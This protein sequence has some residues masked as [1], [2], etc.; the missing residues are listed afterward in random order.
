MSHDIRIKKGLNIKLK[1]KAEKTLSDLPRTK[2]YAIKPTDFHGI[3]PK[4][5]IKVGDKVKAIGSGLQFHK[6]CCQLS[7]LQGISFCFNKSICLDTLFISFIS[8]I[9]AFSSRLLCAIRY[10]C[11]RI[12]RLLVNLLISI[13][14]NVSASFS[15]VFGK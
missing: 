1:G 9:I 2:V 11:W 10:S 4:L 15:S 5:T 13:K 3:V 6:N 12:F 14:C 7:N 8:I